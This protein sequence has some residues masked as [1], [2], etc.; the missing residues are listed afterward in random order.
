MPGASAS[1]VNSNAF[2]REV[3]IGDLGL[4]KSRTSTN[5]FTKTDNAFNAG[6]TQS[7]S[8]GLK[9]GDVDVSSTFTK[10]REINNGR[11]TGELHHNVDIGN[12]EFESSLSRDN[13]KKGLGF[14]KDQDGDVSFNLGFLNLDL[15]KQAKTTNQ[16]TASTANV[17]AV[18][19]GARTQSNTQT[20]IDKYNNGIID[21]TDT[22]SSS[23][24]IGSVDRG[25][26]NGI[27]GAFA[28]RAVSNR[29]TLFKGPGLFSRQKRDVRIKRQ[30]Q[31]PQFGR[32]GF[33]T[34]GGFNQNSAAN[35][36]SNNFQNQFGRFGQNTG[37]AISS[38]LANDGSSGQLS[39]A[40]TAQ[41]SY[42]TADGE[43]NKNAAQ[44]QSTNFGP[45]G[46]LDLSNAQSNTMYQRGPNGERQETNSGANSL[47][48]NQF[49]SSNNIANAGTVE[50]NENGVTGE[51]TNANAQSVNSNNFGNAGALSN[52]KTETLHGPNG[53]TINS[54]S[55][56]ASSNSVNNGQGGNV[57]SNA[58]AASGTANGQS[59]GNAFGNTNINQGY[60]GF[61][62]QEFGGNQGFGNQGFGNQGFGNQGFN[63][64]H[65]FRG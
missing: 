10:E 37:N 63:R 18:G 65:G 13:L 35:S 48:Q 14:V 29:N 28:N 5:T 12:V 36:G 8:K 59:F 41:E 30:F 40:N 62:N 53:E 45:N 52:T 6:R 20:N 25:F 21:V 44:G 2:S 32:P 24:A 43:G 33:G 57:S 4:T 50:Y 61:G 1:Q 46:Q 34:F 64:H 51:Q 56:S 15:N 11:V 23:N 27:G 9:V 60:P 17:N 7:L 54:S 47:S 39:A 16:G 26:T 58:N 55:S 19:E 49:G 38:N 22:R 42:Q 31:Y 3:E